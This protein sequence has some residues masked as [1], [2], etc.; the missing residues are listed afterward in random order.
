MSVKLERLRNGDNGIFLSMS[1]AVLDAMNWK[2]GDVLLIEPVVDRK[3]NTTHI[4]LEKKE[5]L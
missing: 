3:G 1:K 5:T 4:V 2:E